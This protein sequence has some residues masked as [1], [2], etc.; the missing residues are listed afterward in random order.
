MLLFTPSSCSPVAIQWN[1]EAANSISNPSTHVSL[2]SSL[3][4]RQRKEMLPEHPDY[5][6]AGVA[7]HA[8]KS[9]IKNVDKGKE[10][11]EGT[12]SMVGESAEE[13]DV[14]KRACRWGCF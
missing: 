13:E 9:R 8:K 3:S 12:P 1:G 2:P 14:E 10:E 4:F 5:A 11:L 6:V 7:R